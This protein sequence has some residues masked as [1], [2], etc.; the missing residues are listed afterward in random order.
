[1]KPVLLGMNSPF[2]TGGALEPWP[3]NSAGWRLWRMVSDEGGLCSSE[4]YLKNFDRRN[5]CLG[6]EWNPA[7]ARTRGVGFRNKVAPGRTTF[8]L[9]KLVWEALGLPRRE[10]LDSYEDDGR[11]ATFIRIPHPSGRCQA[12][13]DPDLRAKVG[14]ALA[15]AIVP[16]DKT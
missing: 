1:M 11:R 6:K 2:P 5:L 7:E 15:S 13:N 10:V 8:V 4:D 16:E 14:K 9:G 3:I 12:Y